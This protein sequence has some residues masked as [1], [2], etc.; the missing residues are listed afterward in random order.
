VASR[1][2]RGLKDAAAFTELLHRHGAE[3]VLHGHNHRHSL[4]SIPSPMGPVPIL[5]VASA[6][7]VPGTPHHHAEYHLIRI[8]PAERHVTIVRRGYSSEHGNI[9]ELGKV[10]VSGRLP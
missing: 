10:F 4:H 5:G 2:G 9:G 3:L 1:F 6:S 8:D 7:A